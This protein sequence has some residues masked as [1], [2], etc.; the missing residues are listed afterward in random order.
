MITNEA[1]IAIC[2]CLHF[3]SFYYFRLG[4]LNVIHLLNFMGKFSFEL[5]VQVEVLKRNQLFL[6]YFST[7]TVQKI[8]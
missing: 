6:K 7:R 3:E 5:A 8:S 4:F 1:K 2:H